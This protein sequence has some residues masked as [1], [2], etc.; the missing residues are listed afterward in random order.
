[1]PLIFNIILEQGLG[2]TVQVSSFLNCLFKSGQISRVLIVLP[3]SVKEQWC[4]ELEAWA[5]VRTTVFHGGSKKKRESSLSKILEKGGICLTTY[6]MI[7][8]SGESLLQDSSGETISW[9]YLICDEGH[10]IKNPSR[11]IS[12]AIRSIDATH[13]LVMTGTPILNKLK[14]MWALFD[15]V[16]PGLLEEQYPSFAR[17]Y[18]DKI[19]D[20]T[21]RD[22][23]PEMKEAGEKAVDAL[24]EKIRPYFLGRKKSEV[25]GQKGKVEQDEER[26]ERLQVSGRKNDL[27]VW[28]KLGELQIELYRKFLDQ[29][30]MI[31]E[32][33][34]KT[35]SP[36]AAI[37]VLRKICDHPSLLHGGI[38][39][40]ESLQEHCEAWRRRSSMRDPKEQELHELRQS[41]KLAFA[42]WLFQT[43]PAAGHKLCIF[44]QSLKMLDMCSSLLEALSLSYERVDGRISDPKE[45]QER[46]DRF[47]TNPSIFAFLITTQVGGLGIS[48]VGAD[49]VL[50][51][52]PSWNTV[53][54]QAGE[55]NTF[56][57]WDISV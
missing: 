23:T 24:L 12:K 50:I 56:P 44:S 47:N 40:I 11:K 14:E 33:L 51:L 8:S 57:R 48:L 7:L 36:L 52:D 43:L 41:S 45:R 4:K 19:V 37:G 15:F 54:D 13:K 34:N 31:N 35:R 55:K 21:R 16:R 49:R 10:K 22:A 32:I 17:K 38:S 5:Q 18:E 1:M 39:D 2:K 6:G 29:K 27:I 9:D 42:E 53:D 26:F 30:D 25:F 3:L 20:G 28:L 46:I